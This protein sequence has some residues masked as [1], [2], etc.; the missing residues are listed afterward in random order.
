MALDPD[1]RRLL[2]MAASM[3]A[4]PLDTMPV[5]EARAAVQAMAAMLQPPP[6][7]HRMRAIDLGGVPARLYRPVEAEDA[8]ILPAYIHL[9]GG[10]W[11]LGDLD[12]C[13]SFCAE[14][15]ATAG[16]AVV[17]VDYRLA[18]E[19]PFPAGLEDSLMAVRQVVEQA[20]RLGIDPTRLS[21][22]GDSAGGNL[23]ASTCLIL[24]D[25]DGEPVLRA[26]MLLYPVTD[27]R[28]QTASYAIPDADGLLTAG[29]MRWFRDLYA[30]DVM[31]WRVS[32]L[33]A[34]SHAGLPPAYIITCGFDPLRDEG[35][36]YAAALAQAGGSVTHVPY[37]NQFHGF[38]FMGAAIAAAGT[39]IADVAG[40]LRN[41]L[42]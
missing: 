42:R 15:A 21:I 9:H 19:H 4:P 12:G 32:P 37:P 33:L 29:M 8:A 14:I 6:V 18:P 26:Q 13:H 31:D 16:I 27:L 17:A 10:G 23:A 35:R 2:D 3:G 38:L 34:A 7:P 40:Y 22:G 39:A 1:A 30:G 25:G 41:A 5:A 11:V 36:A 20:A 28:M 24:R